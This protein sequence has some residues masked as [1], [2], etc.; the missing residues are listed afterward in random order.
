MILPVAKIASC[1]AALTKSAGST[2]L[3]KS[4]EYLPTASSAISSVLLLRGGQVSSTATAVALDLG[5]ESHLITEMASYGSVTAL[6]LNAALRLWTS[7]KFSKDQS[8]WISNSFT[9]ST[10]LCVVAGAFTAVLFQLLGIYSR[11]ALGMGNDEGYVAFKTATA[12]YRKWGFRCFLTELLTLVVS[13]LL[14]LYNKLW[15]EAGR[16][17]ETPLLKRAGTYIMA[18]SV[19]LILLGGYHIQKVLELATKNIF[20]EAYHDKFA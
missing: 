9:I 16:Q 6:V 2:M 14:S 20:I 1:Y 19:I 8:P 15:N 3:L 7:T 11:S 13:F 10:T 17:V 12:L 18:G 4:T 5:R